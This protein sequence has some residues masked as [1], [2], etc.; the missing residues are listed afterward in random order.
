MIISL[1][2]TYVHADD[3]A[4]PTFESI[5]YDVLMTLA[6]VNHLIKTMVMT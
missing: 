3:Q 2:Q 1:I 5:N 6:F 4:Q